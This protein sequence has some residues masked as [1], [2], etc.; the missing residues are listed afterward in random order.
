MEAFIVKNKDESIRTLS[1]SGGMFTALTDVIIDEGGIVYG[2]RID[3][4]MNVVHDRAITRKQRNDFCGSKYV[5]SDLK[6]CIPQI[7]NDL[8]NGNVVLFSG[9]PC[10]VSAI[11]NIYESI[12][13]GTLICVDIICH[14][15]PHEICWT[16]YKEYL[17]RKY[18]G[19]IQSFDFRNKEKFGWKSHVETVGVNGKKY[20]IREYTDLFYEHLLFPK[21]CFSCKFKTLHR[22]GDITLGD[23]WGGQ[24]EE[25]E[26]DDNKGVSLVLVNTEVGKSLLEKCKPNITVRRCDMSHYMQIPLKEN[27][28]IPSNYNEFWKDIKV[29]KWENIYSKYAKVPY[30]KKILRKIY[31]CL[32]K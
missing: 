31:Y 11:K 16:K 14:G 9:T 13:K 28:P 5:M 4:Q 30:Y 2:A 19:R 8:L 23:A 24:G 20:N 3:E 21:G 29:D 25:K 17:E 7:K 32:K 15:A 18:N 6:R 10:Q 22:C 12:N 26:F 1:R 27:Y